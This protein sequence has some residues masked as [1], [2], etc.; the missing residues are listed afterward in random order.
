[1]N[2]WELCL[3]YASP[4]LWHTFVFGEP[5]DARPKLLHL[6]V[7][8]VEYFHDDVFEG[9]ALEVSY[10]ISRRW[11]RCT[12]CTGTGTERKVK[13][14]LH[15]KDLLYV[16]FRF[17]GF[18]NWRCYWT[19]HL[20]AKYLSVSSWKTLEFTRRAYVDENSNLSWMWFK[21]SMRSVR[22]LGFFYLVFLIDLTGLDTNSLEFK[23]FQGICDWKHLSLLVQ[24]PLM[25]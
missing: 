21:Q 16:L 15:V 7:K 18:I 17:S 5:A 11:P 1:M 2:R 6:I 22:E 12:T 23:S 14:P 10:W 8:L 4:H 25:K 9:L 3:G 20:V 19:W 13:S 24:Y